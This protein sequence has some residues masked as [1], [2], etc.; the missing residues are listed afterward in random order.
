MSNRTAKLQQQLL[1]PGPDGWE[2]WTGVPNSRLDLAQAFPVGPG[3][4]SGPAARH[5]LALPATSLWVLPAWLKGQR[6]HLDA[7]AQLHL[8]RLSVRTPGHQGSLHVQCLQTDGDNNLTRIIALKDIA[9]PLASFK[10]LPD[11]CPISAQCYP[12]PANAII[13]WRELGR[14]VVAFT[15]GTQ[16]AYFSP[17]SAAVLDSNGI[18][19]LNNICLQLSFQRVISLIDAVVL[20][21]DEGEIDKLQRAMG[22][23]V[24]RQDRP[25]PRLPSGAV[26]LIPQDVIDARQSTQTSAKR[27]VM[28]LAAGFVIAGIAAGSS[29]M[30]SIASRERDALREKVAEITP[31]AAKIE[32]QKAA[33]MEVASAVDPAHFPMELLL[34]CMEPKSVAEVA[35]LSFECTPQ[36]ILIQG[37]TPE[38]T[39]AL[40][41]TEEIKN[42]EALIAYNW[43]STTPAINPD[44]SASFE[45]KGSIPSKEDVQ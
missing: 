36:H 18:A 7:M 24:M 29:V 10:H 44:N 43:E 40:K 22:L 3:Q 38:I 4:F 41:Y 26:E 17:L 31:R 6:E 32:S 28:A 15:V 12:L 20:W 21:C 35:L 1:L 27:R 45:L 14:L 19:E 33:W 11:N 30:L 25:T 23:P 2:L 42:S 37:R 5:M 13:I 39:P 9:T 8:E 34:R 16:L